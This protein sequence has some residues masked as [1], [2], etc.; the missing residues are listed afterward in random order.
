M[1][2]YKK[3]QEAKEK[4]VTATEMSLWHMTADRNSNKLN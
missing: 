4:L 2:T 1:H 3:D